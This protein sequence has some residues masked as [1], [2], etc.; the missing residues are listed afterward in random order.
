VQIT[1]SFTGGVQMPGDDLVLGTN[2]IWVYQRNAIA[3]N[4]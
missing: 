3:N 4:W 1:Y 2:I